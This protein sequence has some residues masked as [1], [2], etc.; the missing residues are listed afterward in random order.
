MTTFRKSAIAL[1]LAGA[2]IPAVHAEIPLAGD[3]LA[4]YGKIDISADYMDSDVSSSQA[5]ASRTDNV[6]EN[7]FGISS[8]ASRL[9]FRG[10]YPVDS[11]WTATYQLEQEIR[12]DSG[13]NGFATRNSYLGLK[14]GWF[15]EVRIGRHDT[16]FKSVAT[17]FDELGNSVGDDRAILGASATSGNVM[18]IRADNAV[19]YLRGFD[20]GS[21]KL[22]VT[23]MYSADAGNNSGSAPD[24]NTHSLISV[25]ASWMLGPL[26]LTGAL[27][28]VRNLQTAEGSGDATGL[29]MA[30]EY[31]FGNFTAG[32]LLES[33]Q[34]DLN[35]ADSSLQR[36]AMGLKLVHDSGANKL[37]AQFMAADDNDV[38]NNSS[39]FQ[40]AVG[41]FHKL[42][43]GLSA[44][45]I[46][47][48]TSNGDNAA[49]QG[50]DGGHGDELGTLAG[51]DPLAL[52]VGA[53]LKF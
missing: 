18:N 11:A 47:S 32:V 40:T 50:V 53:V 37:V 5:N 20:L 41:G 23:G 8:N 51:H 35:N 29:R 33:I 17:G 24:D 34:H 12:Y 6:V 45:V 39:A 42:G 1:A 10:A 19:M 49:Y 52:S 28:N 27:E 9:G 26:T 44:Y 48:R 15:G 16:P 3:K 30:A 31:G 46:A 43:G 4:V 14:A 38:R 25:G 13:N 2:A 22:K 21:S 36:D 7:N